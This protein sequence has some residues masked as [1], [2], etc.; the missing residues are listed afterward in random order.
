MKYAVGLSPKINV[1]MAQRY[2]ALYY[3]H[4]ILT[5]LLFLMVNKKKIVIAMNVYMY[6]NVADGLFGFRLYS[7]MTFFSLISRPLEIFVEI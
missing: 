3:R 2:S 6:P 4:L 7:D 5:A 1:R